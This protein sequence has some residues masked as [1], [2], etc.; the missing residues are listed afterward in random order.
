VES[1]ALAQLPDMLAEGEDPGWAEKHLRRLLEKNKGAEVKANALC[2]PIDYDAQFLKAIPQEILEKDYGCGDPSRFVKAGDTVLDLGS[3][4]GKVAYIAA[5]AAG[6]HGRVIGVDFNP[7][8]LALARKYQREVAQCIGFDTVEFRRG[9]IQDLGLDLDLLD[10]ELSA[11]PVKSADD[12]L[13]LNE[14]CAKLR[15]ERPLI[16]SDSVDIVLSNCV[17]NLVNEADKQQLFAEIFRVTKS[18]G[19]VAISDIVS[20]ETVPEELKRDPDLWSGCVSGAFEEEAFLRAFESAGFHGIELAKRDEK[21]WRVIEG[22][23]FR[24]VTVTAQK[25]G[26]EMPLERKQAVIYRGP[27]KQVLDDAGRTLE[28]GARQAVSDR[29]FNLYRHE[30]YAQ[31][32]YFVEP[33]QPVPEADAAPFEHRDDARRDPRESKGREFKLTT[34]ADS[35][36]GTEGCG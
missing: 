28:R 15:R 34:E 27:F 22:I 25:P 24:S 29:D 5:Q 17:L 8:M 18:G 26:T 32:F 19:R 14:T 36:C 10:R 13:W 9:K 4:G 23:E 16:A 31:H 30:P 6:A 1:G 33:H 12:Y 7:A 20:D 3:G 11:H 35:C 21:P 2:C